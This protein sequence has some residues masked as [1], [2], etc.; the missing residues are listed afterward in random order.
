MN[1]KH[2]I[3]I[4]C[5]ALCIIYASLFFRLHQSEHKKT[6]PYIICTTSIIGDMVA[7]IGKDTL[8]IVTLMGPGVDPHLY[9]PVES[10]ILKIA[11]A[12]IIFYN[13][14]H[15]EAK[16]AD[17][18]ESLANNQ[19]TVAVT[20]NIPRDQLLAID[21]YETT[22]DPHVW[23]DINLWINAAQT[24]GQALTELAP[25]HTELY[26]NNTHEYVKKL[27]TLL[28][29]TQFI[30]NSIKKE[31]RILISAHDAFS[32]FGRLYECKVVALQGISTESAPGA[33]EVQAIIQLIC[34]QKIPAIFIESSIPVK[35]ILAIQEGACCYGHEVHLGGELYSDALGT[36][37]SSASTYIDMIMHNVSTIAHALHFDYKIKTD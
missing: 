4:C 16:M 11:Y 23:F 21:G 14:L 9:K 25:E 1:F 36:K 8:E 6:K 28:K 3:I 26:Q 30:M 19:T 31:K 13:G 20:K 33:Y 5:T 18:F 27:E 29:T 24:V 7:H 22:Y 12:D 32:Y 15:L 2:Q 37:N 35:N 10:D 34:T 17:L